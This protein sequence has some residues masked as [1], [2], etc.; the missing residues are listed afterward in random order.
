MSWRDEALERRWDAVWRVRSVITGALERERAQ[1][2]I[3]S[4]LE[5]APEVHVADPA[6]LAA[7]DGIDLAE[8]AI[9]SAA[10]AD[11]RRGPRRGLPPARDCRRRRGSK[12]GP[13]PQMR[14]L[15][16]DLGSGRQRSGVSRRHAARRRSAPRMAGGAANQSGMT[17]RLGVVGPALVGRPRFRGADL[18]LRPG[19]QGIHAPHLPNRRAPAGAGDAVL[20]PRAG[21]EPRRFLRLVRAAYRVRPNSA[22]WSCRSPHPWRCGYGSPAPPGR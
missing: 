22:W 18:R 9:T 19:A 15:L 8:I 3:G 17:R 6:L 16:E 2:R 14:S 11:P 1:R 12:P 21:V 5:A 10:D 7:L 13:R 20:R 4:S